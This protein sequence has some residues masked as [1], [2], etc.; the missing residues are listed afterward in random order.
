MKLFIKPIITEKATDQS[1]LNN[2]YSFWVGREMNKLEIKNMIEDIYDVSV[3]KV[4]TFVY[5]G[6]KKV[7]YTKSRRIVG[8]NDSYKKAII[9]L[10]EGNSIDFYNN[11]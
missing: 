6:K 2:R 11:V 1:E 5:M 4:R 3:K 7:K 10:S 9:E 8:R